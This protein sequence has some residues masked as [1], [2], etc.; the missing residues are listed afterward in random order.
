MDWT[1]QMD[2]EELLR[3]AE[4]QLGR[5]DEEFERLVDGLSAE[6]R[7]WSPP[8]GGWG[9]DQVLAHLATTNESYLEP[10]A[11]AIER[12]RG[13]AADRQRPPW[14]P[15]F[16]GRLLIRSLDPSST[17]R[18]FTPRTWRPAEEAP[19]DALER[20]LNS[21]RRL[22]EL[23]RAAGASDLMNGRL[24]SPANRL[25]RLNLGDPFRIFVVHGWRHLGQVERILAHPGFPPNEARPA[26][27]SEG[28]AVPD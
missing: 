6:Q 11:A 23:A 26:P 1:A 9:V 2:Q 15:S 12:A 16:F 24:S 25:I 19:A 8:E 21:Q 5:I 14:R 22:V 4:E 17:R 13:A 18:V 3:D 7:A 20:F 10:L 27:R 28:E